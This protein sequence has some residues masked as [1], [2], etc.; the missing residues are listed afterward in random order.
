MDTAQDQAHPRQDIT[1][2][3]V[4]IHRNQSFARSKL[5]GCFELERVQND[6]NEHKDSCCNKRYSDYK[7]CVIHLTLEVH[8]NEQ[9]CNDTCNASYNAERSTRIEPSPNVGWTLLS[10]VLDTMASV[11]DHVVEIWIHTNV[12][13]AFV[14]VDTS[15]STTIGCID[16]GTHGYPTITYGGY[17]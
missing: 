15:T 6:S 4:C 16:G 5:G 12:P 1:P 2:P 13:K 17:H 14:D 7:T 8:Q 9:H 10:S 3:V 11:A